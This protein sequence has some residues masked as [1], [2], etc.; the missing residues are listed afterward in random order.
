MTSLRCLGT[1]SS[2]LWL[3][4]PSL[5]SEGVM[6]S[7]ASKPH[8]GFSFD[9]SW[10]RKKEG[11]PSF[12]LPAF[13]SFL[14]LSPGI[15]CTEVLPATTLLLFPEFRSQQ[16]SAVPAHTQ[17]PACHQPYSQLLWVPPPSGQKRFKTY[18]LRQNGPRRRSM[19]T[20]SDM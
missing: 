1:N 10:V 17:A 2:G 9:Q 19:L 11:N 12:H 18:S 13:T 8:L 6:D 5:R 3:D 16:A 15:L 20:E 14:P 4:R 7:T